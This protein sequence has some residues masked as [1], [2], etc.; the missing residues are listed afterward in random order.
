MVNIAVKDGGSELIWWLSGKMLS[1]WVMAREWPICNVMAIARAATKLNVNQ[2]SVKICTL[3][4]KGYMWLIAV[5]V[6]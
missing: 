4:K 1:L 2:L 6:R 5:T 3:R